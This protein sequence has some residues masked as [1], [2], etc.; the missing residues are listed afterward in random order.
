MNNQSQNECNEKIIKLIEKYFVPEVDRPGW[1]KTY[2]P[3]DEHVLNAQRS[4]AEGLYN[5]SSSLFKFAI[6][7]IVSVAIVDILLP[8]QAQ[9]YGISLYMFAVTIL[10][11]PSLR[12]R[13][14]IA[15]IT[16]KNSE[17]IRYLE[18]ERTVFTINAFF[19]VL[20]G[21]IL[22]LIAIQITGPDVFTENVAISFIPNWVAIPLFFVCLFLLVKWWFSSSWWKPF[23][24]GILFIFTILI[25]TRFGLI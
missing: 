19:F 18:T 24:Y 15:S 2:G 3:S 8:I 1:K 7:V 23:T 16:E 22:Q 21:V 5:R 6:L 14:T 10:V 4:I 11:Y 9:F 20:I 25:V 17:A 13:Y 12:G